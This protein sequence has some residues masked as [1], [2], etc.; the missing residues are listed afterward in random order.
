LI[1][2]ATL[3]GAKN[4]V[5]WFITANGPVRETRFKKT[6]AAIPTSFSASPLPCSAQ[7][8]LAGERISGREEIE[9]GDVAA[10]GVGSAG[11]EEKGVHVAV[12]DTVGSN[13][14]LDSAPQKS[15]NASCSASRLTTHDS[16]SVWP[17]K[18]SPYGFFIR[19]STPVYPG[20]PILNATQNSLCSADNRRRGRCACRASNC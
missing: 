5:P 1:A 16:G 20:A 11:D 18:P 3:N 9:L 15:V 7:D 13:F 8:S 14:L 6:K 4:I 2:V 12:G 10:G 19:S 17:A